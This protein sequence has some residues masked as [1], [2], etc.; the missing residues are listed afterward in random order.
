[1]KFL[2]AFLLVQLAVLSAV[3]QPLKDSQVPATV[4]NSFLAK[5]PGTQAKWESENGGYEVNFKWTGKEMSCVIDKTGNIL[6]TETEIEENE[7][8]ETARAYISNNYPGSRIRE[9]AKIRG[10][11]K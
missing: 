2:T 7:L 8:P 11:C 10:P 4:K 1:M 3:A 9:T 6:E 5:Y